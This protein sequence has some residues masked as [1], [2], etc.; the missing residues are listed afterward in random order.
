VVISNTLPAAVPA[1]TVRLSADKAPTIVNP[2]APDPAT[3]AERVTAGLS[4]AYRS[5]W[6]KVPCRRLTVSLHRDHRVPH[7]KV[8]QIAIGSRTR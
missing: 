6:E 2:N 7:Q 1:T 3:T 8:D 5:V 4:L